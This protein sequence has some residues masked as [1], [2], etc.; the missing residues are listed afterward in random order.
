MIAVDGQTEVA[1]FL[2]QHGFGPNASLLGLAGGGRHAVFK[3]S[4]G[5]RCAV[6]K[7]HGKPATNA[8]LDS[9]ER[10]LAC[11]EFV[12]EHAP[13]SCPAI[14]GSDAASRSLLFAWV[15][16][17]KLGSESVDKAAVARM[18]EFL[19]LINTPPAKNA[20]EF[21]SLPSAS[22]AGLT[23][24]EHL[25][26]TRR[27]IARLLEA[28]DRS[29]VVAEMKTFVATRVVPSVDRWEVATG[30]DFLSQSAIPVFSPSDFGFHNVLVDESGRFI[31]I[32][33]EHA[34]WDDAAKLCADFLIQPECVLPRE[35]RLGF[36]DGIARDKA[37]ADDLAERTLTLLPLQAAKWTLIVLNPFV[38]A[39]ANPQLL[40]DRLNKARAYFERALAESQDL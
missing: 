19:K 9:F 31:F 5:S 34:G 28:P 36:L 12:A 25:L 8:E 24:R 20:A 33:F 15:E 23:P 40:A 30:S 17:A 37:F 29:A 2:S 1:A 35:L 3:V 26:T 14:I 13:Q 22:E 21:H 7:R 4:D 27:R 18:A 6:L 32:D 39:N 10:E 11:H 38:A 16:G